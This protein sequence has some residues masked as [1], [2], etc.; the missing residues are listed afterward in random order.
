[1]RAKVV[2]TKSLYG[3]EAISA[4]GEEARRVRREGGAEEEAK[5]RTVSDSACRDGQLA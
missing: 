3:V 4:S 1:M 5:R 2:G